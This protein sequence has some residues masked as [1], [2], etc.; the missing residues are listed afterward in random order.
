MNISSILYA[1]KKKISD[2]KTGFRLF[3]K[4]VALIQSRIISRSNTVDNQLHN[5]ATG[6]LFETGHKKHHLLNAPLIPMSK[7]V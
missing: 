4:T 7:Q 2:R 5:A 3:C 1:F 6:H